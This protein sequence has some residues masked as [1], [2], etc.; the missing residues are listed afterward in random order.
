MFVAR[1][2]LATIALSLCAAP[3]LAQSID[4]LVVDISRT[5]DP[6]TSD[7]YSVARNA[8][9]NTSNFGPSGI[10]QRQVTS[11]T[12]VSEITAESLAGIE[13]VLLGTVSGIGADMSVLETYVQNGGGL[14]VF[15][16]NAAD[17]L[18]GTFGGTPGPGNVSGSATVSNS[19]SPLMNGPFGTIPG[20]SFITGASGSYATLPAGGT[21]AM[22]NSSGIFAGSFTYGSGRVAVFN[23]EE[24]FA[25]SGFTGGGA[26]IL[27]NPNILIAFENSFAWAAA[28]PEPSLGLL[29]AAA[30]GAWVLRRRRR[31]AA[32][33]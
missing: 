33:V 9:L 16:D 4:V 5:S 20:T 30:V 14:F 18:S 10:V 12:A 26:Y 28:V 27:T 22:T 3:A 19:L 31:R 8:I 13:I 29:P 7:G 2:T 15:N 25:N 6:F 21:T 17:F 23:D 24:L 11:I 32:S 1:I